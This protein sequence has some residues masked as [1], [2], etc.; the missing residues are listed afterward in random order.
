MLEALFVFLFYFLVY[1]LNFPLKNIYL[2]VYI[3]I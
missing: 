3:N 2:Y 1:S